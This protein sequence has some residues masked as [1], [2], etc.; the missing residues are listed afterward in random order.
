MR[1]SLLPLCVAG[2]A[3]MALA[4]VPAAAAPFRY[5][6]I[7]EASAAAR[8]DDTHFAVASDEAERILIYKRGTARAV[9]SFDLANVSDLEGAVRIG[10]RVYWLTSHSLNKDGLDK[11]K[12][13]V[14][15][16]TRIGAGPSLAETGTRFTGLRGLAA[17][18]LGT[19]EWPLDAA[20]NIEGLAATPFGELLL[21]L[22]G[23]L[24]AGKAAIVR[25]DRGAHLVGLSGIDGGPPKVWW[26]DLGGRGI[27]SLE[28]VGTGAHSYLIVAGATRDGDIA[29]ALFWWDGTSSSVTAGPATSLA[30]LAPEALIAWG[31]GTYQILG[32]NEAGCSDEDDPPAER[33][34]PSLEIRP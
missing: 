34:F 22:R 27:R 31:D 9:G 15:A 23:P 7:C 1:N 32:D 13:K 29:P 4:T 8:L 18:A 20:L 25:L 17:A 2:P 16:A 10:T 5:E 26:L 6:G 14:L 3:A 30:G 11:P 21:G 33:W 12:R 19:Q 28:R 24:K